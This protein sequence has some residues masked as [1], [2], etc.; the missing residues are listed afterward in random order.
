[1]NCVHC[2]TPLPAG[3]RRDRC[4]CDH[5][6]RAWAS[7][8]RR[9]VGA[10][11]PPRWQHPALQS[12]DPVL[13]AAAAHAKQL[14]EAHGWCRSTARWVMDGLVL[15]LNGRAAGARVSLT[16]IRTKRLRNAH[17][18]A[19]VLAD[20]DLLEGDTTPTIRSW[21]DRYTSELSAGFAGPVRGWLLVLLEGDARSRP[22]SQPTVYRYFGAVR[23]LIKCWSATHDHLREITTDDVYDV[24][25]PLRGHQRR[26]AVAALRSL[27]R[28]AKKRGV[29]F[30]NPTTGLKANR[31]D[32]SLLPMTDAEIRAVAQSA[33][34]PAQ[35]LIIALAAIHA[36]RTGAIRH[37]TLDDLDIPNQRITIGGH[38]QR[39]AELTG[40]VLRAWLDH[41][42][43]TWPHTPNR[44]VL[45]A[46]RT[47]LGTGPI[48]EVHLRSHLGQHGFTI[49]RIRADRILHEALS[50]GPD[51]LHLA[52]VF[53]LSHSTASRYT[54]LAQQLLDDGESTALPSH[55]G[56]P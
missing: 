26:I 46:G 2:G 17:R 18:L 30:T 38:L 16:E 8:E 32:L 44:H 10:S 20:L 31:G 45:I 27:F 29:V 25:D 41:R 24:L 47:A 13:Q 3:S 40:R 23:P 22:R 28:Y 5:K 4:Y 50:A 42:R 37:L 39:L 55:P 14:G 52:L 35:R 19:E 33:R 54:A 43:A 12:S 51:P 9:K 11:P 7:I 15:L 34:N 6:C 48:S 1:V 49:D 21:I 56:P 36:A 53:N